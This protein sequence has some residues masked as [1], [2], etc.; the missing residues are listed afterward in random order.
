VLVQPVAQELHGGGERALR[1]VD[2]QAVL[3]KDGKDLPE[4]FLLLL[5]RAAGDD[6]VVQVAEHKGRC[7]NSLSMKPLES[8]GGNAQAERNEEVLEQAE[9]LD[10]R[11]F[12]DDLGGHRHLMLAFN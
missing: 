11:H 9:R 2:L 4:M 5:Q 12:G 7:L 6:M 8:L 3:L 1:R 10:N